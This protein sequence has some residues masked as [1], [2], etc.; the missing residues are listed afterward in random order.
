L[1]ADDHPLVRQ[2]LISLLNNQPD[3]KVVGEACNGEEAIQLAGKLR[4]NVAIIDITMPG[5]NGLN[6]TKQI[7]SMFPEIEILI[8]TVHSDIEHISGIFEAGASGYLTKS[9]FGNEIVTAVRSIMAGGSVLSKHILKQI[10]EINLQKPFKPNKSA[11]EYNLTSRELEIFKMASS[12]MSNKDIAQRL[13]LS[14]QTVKGYLVSI[15]SKLGVNSRTKAV[16]LGLRTGIL[17]L[18]DLDQPL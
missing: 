6:A 10:L 15:F 12:G 8:L 16:I 17:M 3:L 4:P 13:N 2:A 1:I 14:L 9:V 7:K 18:K 5:I 11:A